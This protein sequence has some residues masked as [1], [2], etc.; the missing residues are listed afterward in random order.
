MASSEGGRANGEI[1]PDELDMALGSGLR[2]L[3]AQV[4]AAPPNSETPKQRVK[5]EQRQASDLGDSQ[6]EVG[7][8][9]VAAE[10]AAAEAAA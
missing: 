5:R 9:R 2:E 7:V 4:P 6:V 8:L 3:G 1:P 10:A